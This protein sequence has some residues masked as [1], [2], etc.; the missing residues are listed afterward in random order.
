M[1]ERKK[2]KELAKYTK[3]NKCFR[4]RAEVKIS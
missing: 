3:K 4:L 1:S 2:N